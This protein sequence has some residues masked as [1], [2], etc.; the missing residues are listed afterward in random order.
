MNPTLQRRALRLEKGRQE[1]RMVTQPNDPDVAGIVSAF[2]SKVVPVANQ[3]REIRILIRSCNDSLPRRDPFH[4][5]FETVSRKSAE[6][7]R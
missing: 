7:Y 4:R 5:V 3:L 1:E 6:S 2:D